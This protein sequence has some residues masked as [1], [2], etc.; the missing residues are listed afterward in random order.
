MSF[1]DAL[2]FQCVETPV[3]STL[4]TIRQ[5][6]KNICSSRQH[7]KRPAIHTKLKKAH[8]TERKRNSENIGTDVTMNVQ[9]LVSSVL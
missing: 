7:K 4:N 1:Y 2:T 3:E 6:R 9:F 8:K 5:R